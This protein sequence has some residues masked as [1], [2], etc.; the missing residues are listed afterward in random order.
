MARTAV[1]ATMLTNPPDAIAIL[2]R[3][4][5]RLRPSCSRGDK[6]TEKFSLAKPRNVLGIDADP[7][8]S[9]PYAGANARKGRESD[10]SHIQSP[11]PSHGRDGN[12]GRRDGAGRTG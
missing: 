5:Q 10:D 1:M 4:L 9:R 8:R 6:R 12:G 7:N 3:R 2:K 11:R